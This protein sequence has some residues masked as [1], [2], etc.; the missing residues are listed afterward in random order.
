MGRENRC[1]LTRVRLRL[2]VLALT[3]VLF[4]AALLVACASETGRALRDIH[5]ESRFNDAL[6]FDRALCLSCHSEPSVIKSTRNYGG[7]SGLNIHQPPESMADKYGECVTCH[8][9]EALPVL[10]CNTADC[11]DFR[12]PENWNTP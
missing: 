7:Q 2:R 11:H 12:L 8:K 5:D 1:A 4:C 3:I 9:V 6:V 10:T